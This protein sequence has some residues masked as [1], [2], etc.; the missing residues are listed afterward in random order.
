M[1]I[2]EL[3]KICGVSPA[4]VSRSINGQVPVSQETR[5]KINEAIIRYEYTPRPAKRSRRMEKSG[6]IGVMLPA[7]DHPF[8][9]CLLLEI[10]K[11]IGLY[12]LAMIVLPERENALQKQLER[13]PLDGVILLSAEITQDTI[14]RLKQLGLA[15]I[16]CSALPLSKNFSSVHV[17]DL[18]AAYDGTRYLLELGHRRIGF[19]TDS[20]RSIDS[21]FQRIT[22]CRKA[23]EDHGLPAEDSLFFSGNCD[24]DSGFRGAKKLLE[25]HRDLTAL[26]AHSDIGAIGA[27]AAL[28]DSGIRVPSDVSVLGFDGIWSGEWLRPRLTCVHQPVSEIV[29]KT[30]E[31]LTGII[32][33]PGKQSPLSII[34]KHSIMFRESCLKAPS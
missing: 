28:A 30:L 7:L 14:D 1:T 26:F 31:L 2:Q 13:L 18:A 9:Q 25:N 33:N 5:R 12:H 32:E 15:I 22:G 27:I 16:M 29:E 17:D 11:Q 6:L 34:L 8:A 24:Y 23:M 20:P 21:G 19:I 4:T 3:A 10:Q